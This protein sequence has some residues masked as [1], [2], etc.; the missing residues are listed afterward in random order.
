MRKNQSQAL[1][2]ISRPKS[3][4]GNLIKPTASVK[5]CLVSYYHSEASSAIPRTPRMCQSLHKSRK[6]VSDS[7]SQ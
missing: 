3:L 1:C 7:N 6:R 5:L 2:I 4:Q